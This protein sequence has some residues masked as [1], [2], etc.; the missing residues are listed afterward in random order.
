MNNQSSG[1]NNRFL[2]R[3]ISFTVSIMM[4]EQTEEGKCVFFMAL[5][6]QVYQS[7]QNAENGID[8]KKKKRKHEP[9]K[10]TAYE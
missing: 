1:T 2:N 9:E 3:T 5:K 4:G 8:N 10:L 6:S 7:N